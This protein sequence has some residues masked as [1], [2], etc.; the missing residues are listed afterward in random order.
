MTW[1][2]QYDHEARLRAAEDTI[3]DLKDDLFDLG[4]E[5]HD[6]RQKLQM[7]ID[8]NGLNTPDNEP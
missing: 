6:L 4:E 3:E 8:L 2:D 1:T 5:V 7:V